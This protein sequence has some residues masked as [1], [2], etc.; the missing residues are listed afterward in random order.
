MNA[1]YTDS[2]DRMVRENPPSLQIQGWGAK[3]DASTSSGVQ[4]GRYYIFLR[5]K[6]DGMVQAC[7]G[8]YEVRGSHGLLHHFDSYSIISRSQAQSYGFSSLPIE[9]QLEELSWDISKLRIPGTWVRMEYRDLTEDFRNQVCAERDIEMFYS[10][11]W[12]PEFYVKQASLGYISVAYREGDTTVLAPR[13]HEEFSLLEWPWLKA[14]AGVR[15]I[16]TNGQFERCSPRLQVVA[17]PMLVIS[18]LRKTWGRQ[19]W[20]LPPYIELMDKIASDSVL[21][22]QMSLWGTVLWAH[23]QKC[24]EYLPAAG[25]LGYTVGNSYTSLSGFFL[26]EKKDFNNFGKLQLYLLAEH[27]QRKG[28]AFWNLG[29]PAMAYKQHLG[30]R[31]VP[32]SQFLPRWDSETQGPAK[33]IALE[34]QS[35]TREMCGSGLFVHSSDSQHRHSSKKGAQQ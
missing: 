9:S 22:R 25:E 7:S 32:C 21:R 13:L 10:F 26:R 23:C 4:G 27:L 17:D 31:D 34:L 20:L 11:D 30:A 28:I 33:D 35:V 24:G 8:L 15:R 16:F 18:Q 29:Q 12:S 5:H 3:P 2:F 1:A 19:S 6:S 14:D